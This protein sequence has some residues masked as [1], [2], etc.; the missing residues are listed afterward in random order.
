MDLSDYLQTKYQTLVNIV[1][2]PEELAK[3]EPKP[4]EVSVNDKLVYSKLTPI[5]GEKGPITF[6][7]NRWHGE[8]DPTKVEQVEN[9]IETLIK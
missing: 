1:H 3:D 4:F 9:E 8:P 5:N 7:Y 2:H 6:K